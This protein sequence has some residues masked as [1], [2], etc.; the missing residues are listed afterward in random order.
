[1]QYR[2]MRLFQPFKEISPLF[3]HILVFM[4][5]HCDL[6]CLNLYGENNNKGAAFEDCIGFTFPIFTIQ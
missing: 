5:E 2:V 3:V 6:K 1:M 4:N